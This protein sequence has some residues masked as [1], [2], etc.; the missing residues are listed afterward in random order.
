MVAG[1]NSYIKPNFNST[2]FNCPH[3]QAYSRQTWFLSDGSVM[4]TYPGKKEE[5]AEFPGLINH[6]KKKPS[7]ERPP[8][9]INVSLTNVFSSFCENCNEISVWVGWRLVWPDAGSAPP[10]NP[11]LPDEVR[12]DYAEAGRIAGASPRGAAALLR[13][14]LQKLCSHLGQPGQNINEDIKAL[15]AE[16]LP[17]MI[18]KALDVVRVVGNEAVHPGQIDL[19]DDKETVEGLFRLINLIA[20]HMITVPRHVSEMYDNLPESKRDAIAVRDGHSGTDQDQ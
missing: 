17:P 19:S 15:V 13:L 7:V 12:D 1:Y 20:E 8:M 11:D 3:C 16:G 18:Q 2:A 6:S 4:K 9:H 10:P 5:A 14:A